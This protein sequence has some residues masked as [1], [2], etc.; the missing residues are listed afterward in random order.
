MRKFIVILVGLFLLLTT[1]RPASAQSQTLWYNGN[2]FGQDSLRNHIGGG[3]EA[4]V[5]DDFVVTNPGG[6]QITSA[7][8]NQWFFSSF[9]GAPPTVRQAEWSIRTGMSEGNGGTILASGISSASVTSTGRIPNFLYQEYTIRVSDL[10][11]F[12]APGA[13]WLNVTPLFAG[14]TYLS[15]TRGGNAV[16][17]PAGNNGNSFF[18]WPSNGSRFAARQQDFSMGVAG[19]VVPE[20]ATGVLAVSALVPLLGAALRRR[21]NAAAACFINPV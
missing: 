4:R 17:V 20:P 19:Q 11:V 10:N 12:L 6:W 15:V 1:L 18:D 5:F 8:S 2:L 16:G 7:W 3:T 9:F 13:Y 21:R 14:D